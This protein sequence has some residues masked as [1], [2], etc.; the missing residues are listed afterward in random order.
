MDIERQ[1]TEAQVREQVVEMLCQFQDMQHAH[2]LMED[3]ALD[4]S[5]DF[6]LDGKDDGWRCQA[7]WKDDSRE[8]ETLVVAFEEME[9]TDTAL[10]AVQRCVDLLK[11]RLDVPSAD[12]NGLA[13]IRAFYGVP[14]Q[15]GGRVTIDGKRGMI[16][17]ADGGHLRVLL[18]QDA[19]TVYAHPTWNVV[20]HNETTVKGH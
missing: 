17:G 6:M 12:E 7:W 14:A 13:Y 2:Q 4:Y 16:A 1:G 3:T 10:E 19:S 9:A 8:E 20:Y 15:I 18:D 11:Q 5:V